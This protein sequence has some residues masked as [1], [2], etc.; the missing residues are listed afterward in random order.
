MLNGR[1]ATTPTPDTSRVA[2]MYSCFKGIVVH[3]RAE[4]HAY[5]QSY[6]E[7][8]PVVVQ[9]LEDIDGACDCCDNPLIRVTM[10]V[11]SYCGTSM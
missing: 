11:S 5:M 7:G 6:M 10:G 2:A 4:E 8:T 9:L 1:K 3:A